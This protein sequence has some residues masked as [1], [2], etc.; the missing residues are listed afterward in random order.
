MLIAVSTGGAVAYGIG[1]W[2]IL[3]IAPATVTGLKGQWALLAAGFL[4]IGFVWMIAAF[5]LARPDSW[6]SRRFYGPDKMVRAQ[7]RYGG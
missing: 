5:R 7:H 6:W 2:L 3:V 4:T 1:L